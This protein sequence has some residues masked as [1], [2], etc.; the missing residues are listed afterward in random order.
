MNPYAWAMHRRATYATA[1][2]VRSDRRVA[3]FTY[4]AREPLTVLRTL[5]GM[6][7]TH[8]KP[9]TPSRDMADAIVAQGD[10]LAELSQAGGLLK[11]SSRPTLNLL[12][13]LLLLLSP[14]FSSSTGGY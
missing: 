8:L 4:A 12:L 6:L 13:L 11:T 9:D 14:C 1:A 3:G 7:S 2:A 5:G 10:V